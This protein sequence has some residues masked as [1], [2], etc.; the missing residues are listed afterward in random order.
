MQDMGRSSRDRVLVTGFS[1]SR[2]RVLGDVRGFGARRC[3]SLLQGNDAD[4][5]FGFFDSPPPAKPIDERRGSHPLLSCGGGGWGMH[6]QAAGEGVPVFLPDAS[7]QE[8][9]S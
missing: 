5:V 9:T 4:A 3:C 2:V 7:H 8:V 6:P 1:S